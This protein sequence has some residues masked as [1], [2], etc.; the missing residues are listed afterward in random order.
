MKEHPILFSGPMVNAILGG[1]KTMTRRVVKRLPCDCDGNWFPEEFPATTTE[2][3]QTI[4]HS[5]EWWCSCCSSDSIKCPYGK[6]GDRLWVRETWGL[7]DTQ[8]S[9][10]PERAQVFYRAT[11]GEKHHLRHQ[12]WRPSIFMPRWASRITLE[13]ICIRVERLHEID[14]PD[15]KK[16]GVDLPT[17]ELFPLTNRNFKLRVQFEKLWDSINGKKY[18]WKSN[19]WVWVI[20]F[21]RV[22]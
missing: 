11:D 1:R 4:G 20:E 17:T 7:W 2:G 13:I 3:W 8:P 14:G 22:L 6:P 12:L 19:P 10:G 5:G 9:D 18:P 15:S 16:E 21:R